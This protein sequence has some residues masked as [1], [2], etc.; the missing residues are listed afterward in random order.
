M[1]NGNYKL[2][3]IKPVI[4][5]VNLIY[6]NFHSVNGNN[7]YYTNIMPISYSSKLMHTKKYVSKTRK[8]KISNFTFYVYYH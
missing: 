5:I 8:K 2:A 1:S 3:E 7:Q 4:T 6:T